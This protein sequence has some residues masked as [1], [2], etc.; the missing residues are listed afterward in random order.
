MDKNDASGICALGVMYYEGKGVP[1]DYKEAVR[2]TKIAIK[3]N[4]NTSQRNLGEFY[5]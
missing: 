3:Q 1:I 2:I 5:E 4:D